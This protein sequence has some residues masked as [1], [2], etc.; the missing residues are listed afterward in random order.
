MLIKWT[1]DGKRI[2]VDDDG[3]EIEIGTIGVVEKE[4]EKTKEV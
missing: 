1:T 3:T 2:A 4:D